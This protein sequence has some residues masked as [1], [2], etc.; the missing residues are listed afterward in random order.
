MEL[1]LKDTMLNNIND[2]DFI[3]IICTPRYKQRVEE[4]KSNARFELDTILAK[5]KK[6]VSIIYEKSFSESVP[7]A[8]R[9]FLAIDFTKTEDYIKNMVGYYNPKGIIPTIFGV[10]AEQVYEKMIDSFLL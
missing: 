2:S 5:N 4:E 6:V 1:N 3:I 10:K 8:I 7:H 9:D